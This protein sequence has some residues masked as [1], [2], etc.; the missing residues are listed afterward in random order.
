MQEKSCGM[1]LF[2]RL[3]NPTQVLLIKH[4]AG[5]W[6]FPKGHCEKDETEIETALRETKEETGIKGMV[7]NKS[8]RYTS[9]YTLSNGNTKEVVFFVGLR[10]SGVLTPQMSEVKQV[11]WIPIKKA[12]H[13]ITHMQDRMLLN[14]V[15]EDLKTTESSNLSF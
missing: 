8:L 4:N 11:T 5:H 6:S 9:H 12:F 10:V 2:D 14:K 7:I 1:I 15:L 13:V 3:K